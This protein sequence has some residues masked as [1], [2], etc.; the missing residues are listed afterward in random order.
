[1]VYLHRL[2]EYH[3]YLESQQHDGCVEH[4]IHQPV[5]ENYNLAS[6]YILQ[7]EDELDLEPMQALD[8]WERKLRWN[9]VEQPET[10]V[11][12]LAKI[13]VHCA[14]IEESQSHKATEE[15]ESCKANMI[16]QEML[17]VV[18]VALLDRK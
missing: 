13:C 7:T 3:V 4:L 18:E 1:M 2:A 12:H 9:T 5:V 16:D 8:E 6:G 17:G 15:S 11:G 14:G 10:S